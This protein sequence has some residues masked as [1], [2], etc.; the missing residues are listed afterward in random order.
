MPL[1]V[2]ADRVRLEGH[3]RTVA[4]TWRRRP[5]GFLDELS[6][7]QQDRIR[8]EAGR[9]LLARLCPGVASNLTAH[10]ITVVSR[11]FGKGIERGRKAR[12]EEERRE[13]A[14]R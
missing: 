1:L 8:D 6:E 2:G 14:A 10:E 9:H 11:I 5:E 3:G 4:A 7:H 12:R 13:G